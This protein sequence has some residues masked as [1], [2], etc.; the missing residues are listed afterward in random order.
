MQQSSIINIL[1]NW[2]KVTDEERKHVKRILMPE[3]DVDRLNYKITS[4]PMLDDMIGTHVMDFCEV[5]VWDSKSLLCTV[6]VNTKPF[7]VSYEW[8]NEYHICF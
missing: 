4:H 1:W 3:D 5:E 2:T 6:I 8:Y 7:N